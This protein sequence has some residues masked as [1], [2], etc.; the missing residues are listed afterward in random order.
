MMEGANSMVTGS[1][2][3]GRIKQINPS[4]KVVSKQNMMAQ[5][6]EHNMS[7]S[8]ISSSNVQH[9]EDI[10]SS[11]VDTDQPNKMSINPSLTQSV[12]GVQ[13]DTAKQ[14]LEEE[15]K[16]RAAAP[17]DSFERPNLPRISQKVNK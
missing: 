10:S 1:A 17:I 7:S 4:N 15:F 5:S 12:A 16:S 11:H 3:F 9:E 13:R 6:V 8:L 2:H 14:E